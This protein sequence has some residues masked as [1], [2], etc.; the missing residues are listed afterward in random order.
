M[1]IARTT[2]KGRWPSSLRELDLFAD[3]SN[4]ELRRI[5][6][7]MTMLSVP[8]G[9]VLITEGS[10]GLEFMIIDEGEA[11]VS[12]HA[13]RGNR[14]VATLHRGDFAGEMSLLEHSRRTATVTA[15]T[16]LTIYV[17]NAAEFST[18]LEVAPSVKHKII[19]AADQRSAENRAAA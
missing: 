2:L 13:G 1:S 10:I 14:P 19:A 16:P 11:T 17:C 7:L 6:S 12:L 18:L 9:T 3:C 4:A 5:S 8:A 15:T